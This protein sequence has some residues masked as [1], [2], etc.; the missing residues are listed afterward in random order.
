[1]TWITIRFLILHKYTLW[2]KKITWKEKGFP[3]KPAN[4]FFYKWTLGL[5][6]EPGQSITL[7]ACEMSCWSVVV[8]TTHIVF[9]QNWR[10]FL[11]LFTLLISGRSSSL[12]S[13]RLLF[14]PVIPFVILWINLLFDGV[15]KKLL[16]LRSLYEEIILKSQNLFFNQFINK[17]RSTVQEKKWALAPLYLTEIVNE[18]WSCWMW[19]SR[20]ETLNWSQSLL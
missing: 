11:P 2:Y 3:F 6:L 18:I 20:E 1:M 10:S 13:S 14:S 7:V 15:L 8:E 5:I 16:C 19:W 9:L 12:L 4:P 17:K